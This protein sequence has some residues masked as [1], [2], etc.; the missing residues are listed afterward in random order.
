MKIEKL[1]EELLKAKHLMTIYAAQHS[2][3]GDVETVLRNY[4]AQKEGELIKA[5]V[6]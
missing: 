5:Y 2:R 6:K 4:I 1:I 3:N